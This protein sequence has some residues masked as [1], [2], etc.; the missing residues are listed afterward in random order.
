MFDEISSRNVITEIL[1]LQSIIKGN[2]SYVQCALGVL[3][4]S[5]D[6]Q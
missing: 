1:L 4:V 2:D 6:E 5:H 3:G